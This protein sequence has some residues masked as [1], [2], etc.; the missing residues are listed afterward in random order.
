[1]ELG[2]LYVPYLAL[3]KYPFFANSILALFGVAQAVL[4][5]LLTLDSAVFMGI[6]MYSRLDASLGGRQRKAIGGEKK[7]R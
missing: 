3:C 5:D 7:S 2:K 6:D 1:M 4:T